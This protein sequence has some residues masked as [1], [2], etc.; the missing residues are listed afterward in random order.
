MATITDP[1]SLED[2]RARVLEW[3]GRAGRDLPW[4]ATRDPYRVLVAEVLAQQT[5]AARAAA[6]WPRFLERFPDVAA[7]AAASPAE[8]LRAWQG[9]GYNRRALA[10]RAAAQAVVERGGWPDTV[11]GLAALPGIGP[12]T[13]R[14][15]A[16]FALGV[17]V[18][19]VDTNVARV[20][21]R[22]LTGGDPSAL[23]PAGRQRLADAAMP[24]GRAW[25][26][27]SAL[28]DVGALH[29]RPRPR[30]HGCPLEPRC[31]WRALGEE[32]PAAR[33]RRQAPFRSSDRRW[34]GAVVRAL[35]GTADGL[36]PA[37]LAEVVDADAAGRADGWFE[38]LLS[39]LEGE[40]LIARGPDGR[41]RLPG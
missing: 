19:P 34:R 40:G 14:A 33:V 41:V 11:E 6:A 32:A 3:F 21:A 15:V 29:C 26:W 2:A 27:S 16:C 38:G 31:R 13:A 10:L 36:G 22:A 17:E 4:R 1:T 20:L 12:Y 30:C 37:E 24:P 18:A 25:E 39:R 7:L 9:L 28:M 5:Q 8:V 35:A 23:G